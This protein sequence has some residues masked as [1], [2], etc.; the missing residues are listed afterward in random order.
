MSPT[1]RAAV[2]R[3]YGDTGHLRIIEIDRPAPAAHEVLVEVRA[4]GLSPGDRAM[5]TGIP[6]INRL[7]ASGLRRPKHPVPGFD[8]AGVVTEVGGDVTS[9]EIGDRV[10][11]NAPGSFAEFAI[12]TEDQIASIP[13]GWSFVDAAAVPESGCVALQAV[14]DHAEITADQRVAVLGAG[15]GV[16][17]YV[18]QLAVGLG[19]HVTAVCG[20]RMVDAVRALGSEQVLDYERDDVTAVDPPFDVIIDA[21]GRGSLRS[22]RRAL[23]PRGRLV[24]VGA[25]HRHRFTGGLG[26]WLRA[27]CWSPFVGQR[28][29]PFAA[30]PLD[31]A[32]LTALARLME[33]GTLRPSVDHTYPLADAAA[34]MTRLDHRRSPGKVVVTVGDDGATTDPGQRPNG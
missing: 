33:D 14:R 3:V 20:S 31:R 2:Q 12:A 23:T 11:G 25:D 24:I 16:G 15:G 27:L 26:R 34:A 13:S 4:A 21:A 28:L 32:D 1:M 17:C 18:V 22:L 9:V 8:C 5:L 10:F 30:R 29:R 7:A 19:A 6:Y